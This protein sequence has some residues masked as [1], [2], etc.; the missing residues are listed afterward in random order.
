MSDTSTRVQLHGNR[1]LSMERPNGS[2]TF[3]MHAI[4]AVKSPLGHTE[5]AFS[6]HSFYE[7]IFPENINTPANHLVAV[8]IDHYSVL[9]KNVLVLAIKV[10]AYEKQHCVCLDFTPHPYGKT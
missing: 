7:T 5:I 10:K 9:A 4:P 6:E 2:I 1:S 8:F 3:G